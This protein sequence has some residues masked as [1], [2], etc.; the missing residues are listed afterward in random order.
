MTVPSMLRWLRVWSP[1]RRSAGDDVFS[2]CKHRK[3]AILAVFAS[4]HDCLPGVVTDSTI[5]RM[6]A[7][8]IGLFARFPV[9][10]CSKLEDV[11]P[12]ARSGFQP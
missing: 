7:S 10:A 4:A 12:T 3:W 1:D 8:V 5:I 6:G 9:R 11:K 2:A